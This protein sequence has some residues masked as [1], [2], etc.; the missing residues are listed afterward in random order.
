MELRTILTNLV[1]TGLNQILPFLVAKDYN[2]LIG[3]T[4]HTL[5]DIYQMATEQGVLR[6]HRAINQRIRHELFEKENGMMKELPRSSVLRRAALV[7]VPVA[8]WAV[9]AYVKKRVGRISLVVV[10]IAFLMAM[11]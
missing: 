10:L 2:M 9:A 5:A 1:R 6:K 8:A 11:E 7:V 4:E 3:R